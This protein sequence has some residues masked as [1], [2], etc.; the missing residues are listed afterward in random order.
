MY[1]I[2]VNIQKERKSVRGREGMCMNCPKCG[3]K[4]VDEAKYCK[5]CGEPLVEGLKRQAPEKTKFV[6]VNTD[7]LKNRSEE[8][9][10]AS[11][12][13]IA[14]VAEKTKEHLSEEKIADAKNKAAG[15]AE[16]AKKHVSVKKLA[17]AGGVI[18]IVAGAGMIFYNNSRTIQLDKYL[19][20]ETNGYTGYGKVSVS[21]DW[22]TIKSKYGNKLSFTK[23]AKEEYGK[24]V[25]DMKPVELLEDEIRVD[26][27][28]DSHLSNGD[29]IS[30]SWKVDEDLAGYV[31]C[32]FKYKDG[33]YQVSDLK[34]LE[35]FDAFA[36]LTVE[37][38]GTSPYGKVGIE[39]TGN[40]LGS[41][42]FDYEPDKD[43]SNGDIVTV[44]INENGI[45]ESARNGRIPAE[46]EKEYT[47][48]GL[49]SVVTKISDINEEALEKMKQQGFDEWNAWVAKR[50]WN[51]EEE[52]PGD[53]SYRGAYLLT[54]KNGDS[55]KNLLYLAY[56]IQIHNKYRDEDTGATYDQLNK[57]YRYI[58]YENL[59]LD[60]EGKVK[61]DDAN[62]FAMSDYEELSKFD[63]GITDSWGWSKKEWSYPGYETMDDLYTK[64]VTA[65]LDTYNHEDAAEESGETKAAD[66]EV[67]NGGTEANE[68]VTAEW[69]L[70]DSD[71]KRLTNADIANLSEQERRV[72][73]NEI[74]AR[75]GR[76]FKDEELQAHFD[77]CSWYK[78]TI[79]PE[80]FNE[81]DLSE[82]EIANRDLLVQYRKDH[83]EN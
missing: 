74:Y 83:G 49:E 40:D 15:L 57:I 82:V 75:H 32:K 61:V 47:V 78:G 73:L 81:S 17:V 55:K 25:R 4:N 42:C 3:R 79:E 68:V 70:P 22:K 12:D 19:V 18:V 28:E 67:K 20:F 6:Q 38:T 14:K 45:E 62:Y 27:D 72:A 51:R 52:I 64:L 8:L 60:A 48:D 26:L 71:T 65:N 54:P 21:V 23:K 1:I 2:Y 46:T 50:E 34:E 39:Y 44:K 69:V 58:G 29:S 80:K 36:D 43:L 9:V 37:F 7:E 24:S 35:K 76:K 31:G 56:E 53:I 33:T 59:V 77:S 13:K 5:I 66:I 16:K 30:Y 11:K 41:Y 10:N 63:S